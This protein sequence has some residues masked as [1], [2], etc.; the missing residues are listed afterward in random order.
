MLKLMAAKN[1]SK[2]ISPNEKED[3]ESN[4]ILYGLTLVLILSL[5]TFWHIN[6]KKSQKNINSTNSPDLT[7]EEIKEETMIQADLNQDG[8]IDEKD[9]KLMKE[10]FLKTDAKSLK[11]DLNQDQKVDAK[12]YSLF[13]KIVNK[14]EKDINATK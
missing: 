4:L 14:R 9:A 1:L 6:Y 8:Q 2:K 13:N 12:D 5:I 10:A 3:L 7:V 11:A